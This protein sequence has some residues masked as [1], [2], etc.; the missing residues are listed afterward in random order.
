MQRTLSVISSLADID[1]LG[2]SPAWIVLVSAVLFV[3]YLTFRPKRRDPLAAQPF[4]TSLAQQKSLE[5]DMQN[6]I[7]ELS[8]MTRQM[9]AQ[10]ETRAMK[11]EQLMRDAD[12]KIAE[13][14]QAAETARASVASNDGRAGEFTAIASDVVSTAPQFAQRPAMRLVSDDVSHSE[15]RWAEVYRLGDEGLTLTE[16]ARRLARPNGEVE[17]ILALRPKPTEAALPAAESSPSNDLAKAL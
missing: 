5:R 17:L 4:R 7:V 11:L 12:A 1:A 15:D 16:I 9:S 10:L 14:H 6:V 13:L 2:F 3:M 8:E